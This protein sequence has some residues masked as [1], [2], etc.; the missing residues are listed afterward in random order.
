MKFHHIG[1]FVAD[2]SFGCEYLTSIFP[3]RHIGEPINDP[4][5]CV[6]VQFLTDA[7]GVVYEIV[8]P[9]GEKNPV[10][11]LLRQ[12]KN[13]LNHVAYSVMN[14]DEKLAE[15]KNLGC[16][17]IGLPMPAVAFDARR[18]VFILTRLGFIFEL[19]EDVK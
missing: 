10:S 7:S 18:V 9:Y 3:I 6:Q 19:I 8:A 13:I 17:Q 5:I 14:L 4:G 1:V 15:L 16:I 2:L 12:K 11:N